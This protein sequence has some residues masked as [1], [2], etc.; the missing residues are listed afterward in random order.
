MVGFPA[1]VTGKRKTF[2]KQD[3]VQ[4]PVLLSCFP[5]NSTFSTRKRRL[6]SR[7]GPFKGE[8]G[9]WGSQSPPFESLS[10]PFLS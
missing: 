10:F 9:R 4:I 1:S 6:F 2:W 5:F 7:S 3:M 8:E